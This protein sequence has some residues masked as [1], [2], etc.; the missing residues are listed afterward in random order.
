MHP[1]FDGIV[2]CRQPKRIKAH[3]MKYLVSLLALKSGI[4]ICRAVIVP[5]PYMELGCRGIGEHLQYI[6]LLARGG[7]VV[8]K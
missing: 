7:R 2:F 3:R 1:C 4:G 8:F 6:P 5:V